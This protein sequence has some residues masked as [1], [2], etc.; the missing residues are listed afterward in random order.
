MAYIFR[1]LKRFCGFITGFVFFISGILK[2]MDPTGAGL[3]MDE[4]FRFMHL[5][6]LSPLAKVTG[7]GFAFTETIIGVS[8]I[9]GVWRK[10]TAAAALTMQIFFTILTLF[11]V[12]FNPEMDCG[13]FGEAIHLTHMQTFLKNIVLLLLLS[14]AFIPMK[15]LGE[16]EKKKYVSFSLVTLSIAAFTIYSWLYIPMVDFTDYKS[17]SVLNTAES[18]T[19]EQ[20]MYEAVFIYEKAGKEES[21][22]LENLPDSSWNFV[23]TETILKDGYRRNDINLSFYDDENNYRDGLA[24]EGKVLIISVYDADLSRTQWE[25]IALRL[26]Y[27]EQA[28]LRPLLLVSVP[29][30]ILESKLEQLDIDTR[31]TITDHTYF[32][33]YKTLI[34]LNRS[35]AGGVLFSNGELICKWAS[36]TFPDLAELEEIS[37]KNDTEI[38]IRR[39]SGRSIAFQGFLLYVTA[40]MLLL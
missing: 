26:Q 1:R 27:I 12:I 8:L 18:S 20:D 3:V 36:R 24:S 40:V 4:Y 23:R 29:T 15:D 31:E 11:L 16:P 9:T 37:N 39:S 35:N 14:I 28:G 6:F 30:Q 21:F 33:D 19:S 17:G 7:T 5:D 2:L 25:K 38:S 13:C 10:I 32:S 34:A 22:N